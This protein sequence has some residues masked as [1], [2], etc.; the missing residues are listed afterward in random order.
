MSHVSPARG[1]GE[2]TL[3]SMARRE[4]VRLPLTL[5]LRNGNVAGGATERSMK[6]S[7]RDV[8][9]IFTRIYRSYDVLQRVR[10]HKSEFVNGGGDTEKYSE[11]TTLNQWD[12]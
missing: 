11:W 10:R 3:L 8:L 7:V 5:G 2:E 6:R 9:F 4:E 12:P 1:A